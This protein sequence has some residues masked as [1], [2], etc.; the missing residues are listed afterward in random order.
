MN[1]IKNSVLTLS[2]LLTNPSISAEI[3]ESSQKTNP[4]KSLMIIFYPPPGRE[5]E[6]LNMFVKKQTQYMKK[7]ANYSS[8]SK[9]I[10]SINLT[11]TELGEPLIHLMIYRDMATYE[12]ARELFSNREKLL[13]YI[14]TH[15]AL[16]GGEPIHIDFLRN[17]KIHF[18]EVVSERN[19]SNVPNRTQ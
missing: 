13:S 19:P 14:G 8:S 6:F 1:L 9:Q 15:S 11:P 16:Y 10:N 3:S 7:Y 12:S 18:G 17:S 2:L 5:E 4:D